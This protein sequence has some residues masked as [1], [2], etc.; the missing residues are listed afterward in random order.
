MAT[1]TPLPALSRTPN[2]A[3]FQDPEFLRLAFDIYTGDPQI[4]SLETQPWARRWN[5]RKVWETVQLARGLQMLGMTRP[6]KV[7]LGVGVGDEP[8]TFWLA[9]QCGHV[10]ATDMF[11]YDWCNAPLDILRDPSGFAPYAYPTERLTMM[12]MDGLH[13]V[14]PP[15]SLDFIWS[16]ST[17]EH[18]DGFKGFVKHLE[19]CRRVLKPG[20]IVAF[21]TELALNSNRPPEF[22]VTADR[23]NVIVDLSGMDL[24]FPLDGHVADDVLHRPAPVRLPE[25]KIEDEHWDRLS[26]DL[27][28]LLVTAFTLFLR[29]PGA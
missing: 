9:R 21:S 3:D 25:W 19:E 27:A 1:A 17:V 22:C 13:L 5:L 20:G 6:D 29:K 4:G 15:D 11:G 14:M 10:Y 16:V 2:P 24:A 18:F 23:L 8:L 26:I 28:G 7:G 12:Q